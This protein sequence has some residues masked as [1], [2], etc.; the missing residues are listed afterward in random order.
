MKKLSARILSPLLALL[1][2]FG[3]FAGSA[4]ATELQKIRTGK[5]SDFTRLV[6]QFQAPT[7]FQVKERAAP[8]ELSLL[9]LDATA[10][11]LKTDQAHAS[12][13]EAIEVR[14]EGPHL[15]AVV[16]LSTPGYR[17][18]SFTL[19]EPHRVVVDLYPPAAGASLVLLDKLVIK[20]SA[21]EMPADEAPAQPPAKPETEPPAVKE[22][23]PP[24]AKKQPAALEAQEKAGTSDNVLP[25]EDVP[26]QSPAAEPASPPIPGSSIGDTAPAA[27]AIPP[28]TPYGT[29]QRNL[30][31]V[32]AGI[33]IVIL[34]L[35]FFLLLQKRN[36]PGKSRPVEAGGELTTTAD[37]MASI[38]AR[39]KEK[40]KQYEEAN[41][42]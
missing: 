25:A 10:G 8:H 3:W 2:S 17:L 1:V 24:A 28:A 33:S 37:I 6:F 7:R 4:S 40:F 16:A 23:R 15:K 11:P 42:E 18:K 36:K 26:A 22:T 20:E 35:V 29:F 41:P 34:V 9:F 32:L 5:K 38:D 13:V 21:Q 14:Q 27:E 31:A 19:T 39:I 12:P 30:I